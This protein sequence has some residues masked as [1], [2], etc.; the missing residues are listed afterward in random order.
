[1]KYN[2]PPTHGLNILGGGSAPL[3]PPPLPIYSYMYA[4]ETLLVVH[5]VLTLW[6]FLQ[7][8]T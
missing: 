1:M 2:S 7:V 6:T 4:L 5:I 3:A 8:D